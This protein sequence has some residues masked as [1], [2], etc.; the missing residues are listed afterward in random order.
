MVSPRTQFQNRPSCVLGILQAQLALPRQQRSFYQVS[1]NILAKKEDELKALNSECAAFQGNQILGE[2]YYK[3][4]R[5]IYA[6]AAK[7]PNPIS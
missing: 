5:I 2:T 7:I 3:I 6:L 1:G 4:L